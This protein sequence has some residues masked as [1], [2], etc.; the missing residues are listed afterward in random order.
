ME[1]AYISLLIIFFVIVLI[2][3]VG[4]IIKRQ[5]S[6]IY[7]KVSNPYNAECSVRKLIRENPHAEIVIIV[8]EE[9]PEADEILERLQ[10]D[11]QQIHIIKIKK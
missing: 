10:D 11:F 8:C 4:S 9:L 1:S 7:T 6:F 2:L 3:S 5:T